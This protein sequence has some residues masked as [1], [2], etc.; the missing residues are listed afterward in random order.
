MS[1]LPGGLI[2]VLSGKKLSPSLLA[3]TCIANLFHYVNLVSCTI[4]VPLVNICNF[5]LFDLLLVTDYRL[6][7]AID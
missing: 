2:L 3:I 4:L 6:Y 7:V 5:I 1:F